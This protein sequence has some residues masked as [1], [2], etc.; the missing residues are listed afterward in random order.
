VNSRIGGPGWNRTNDQ[1]I[2]RPA[3]DRL[4]E[5]QEASGVLNKLGR[6]VSFVSQSVL[7]CHGAVVKTVVI[8]DALRF[9]S[10]SATAGGKRAGVSETF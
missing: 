8:T 4:R 10:A 1:P 5:C 6:H 7:E 9:A 2:M 3:P